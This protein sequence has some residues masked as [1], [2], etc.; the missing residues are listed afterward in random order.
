MIFIYKIGH[1]VTF[2]CGLLTF[3][4]VPTAGSK[5]DVNNTFVDKIPEKLTHSHQ[6]L[7]HFVLNFNIHHTKLRV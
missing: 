2:Y 3:K 7:L 6:P 5:C 1:W 4:Q